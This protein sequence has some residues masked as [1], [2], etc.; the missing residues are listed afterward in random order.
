M[1]NF[2]LRAAKAI[3]YIVA[4]FGLLRFLG[5]FSDKQSILLSLLFYVALSE[6]SH[7]LQEEKFVPF[8]VF[9]IP[10]LHNILQDFDLVKTTDAGWGEIRQ[11]IEKLS[12]EH[13]NIWNNKGFLFSFI[14]PDLI[15]NK[16]WHAF[17][18]K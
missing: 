5:G 14:T 15:Y 10:N 8:S 16:D 17:S 18:T 11:G 6:R 12:K 2:L 7:Q 3:V 9:V 1:K 4:L 13:W